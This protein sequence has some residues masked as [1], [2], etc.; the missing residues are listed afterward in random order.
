M[1]ILLFGLVT[2][3]LFFSSHAWSSVSAVETTLDADTTYWVNAF[4]LAS[5][6][7]GAAQDGGNSFRAYNYISINRRGSDWGRHWALRLPFSYNTAGFDDFNTDV[8]QKQKLTLNDVLLDYTISSTLLPGDIEVFTRYRLE[9][10]TSENSIN[11]R[12]LGALRFDMIASHYLTNRFQIEY[13]PIFTWNMHTQTAYENP[14]TGRATSTLI[15]ELN[16]RMSLWYRAGSDL[17]LGFYVGTEDDWYNDTKVNETS[18]TRFQ[19]FSEHSLK[20]GPSVRFTV[21]RNYSF[22]FNVQNIVPLWG[23]SPQR[24][25][26]VSDLGQFKP[27][28]TEFVLL[29]FI[30]F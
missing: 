15:Y 20:V 11:Q 6:E 4:S 27:E 9:I 2:A 24:T 19:N 26:R 17:F 16:Q 1:K 5:T 10:P 29:S 22:L 30:N 3:S 28:Q 8:S 18:R 12:K 23:F 13:W 25:G 21:N 7:A 14:N